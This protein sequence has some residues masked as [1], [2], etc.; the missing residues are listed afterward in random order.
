MKSERRIATG[1]PL[2]ALGLV[3][4][5]AIDAVVLGLTTGYFGG[6]YNS[7]RLAGWS[8]WLAFFAGGAV[9]DACLLAASFALAF[10]L[11]G[12]LRLSG[13]PRTVFA[14]GVA[15]LLPATAD[16]V[17]HQLHRVFGKVLG[18]DLLIELAGGRVSEAVLNAISEAP[19][20]L[21]GLGVAAF[22][23]VLSV[24]VARR[25]ER[26][27]APAA[28]APPSLARLAGVAAG[29]ALAGALLLHAAG[30]HWPV[31]AYGLDRKPAGMALRTIVRHATDWDRDGFGWLSR[32]PDAE[33]FDGTRHPHA[34]EIPGNAI[35]ENGIGGDR[36]PGRP[37]SLPAPAPLALPSA[38]ARPS[39][40]LIF[41]ESFRGDLIG[42]RL[43]SREVTPA[44][45]RLAEEGLSSELAF[46]HS[47]FTWISRAELFQGRVRPVAGAPGLIDDFRMRGYRVAYVS[48]QDDS[49]GGDELIGFDRADFFVDARS[50]PERKTSRTTLA[51]SLQVSW[52]LILEQVQSYLES[53][54]ADDRPVFL[55]V[56]LVDTHFPY[57]HDDLLPLLGV[58]P[59]RRADIR[60]WNAARVFDT[61][62]QSAANVDRAIDELLRIWRE[63]VGDSAIL[64]TADHGQAF[65]EDGM[66]GHGQSVADNQSRVPLVAVGMSGEW[67]EPLGMADLR[68]LILAGL[69]SGEGGAARLVRDPV[70]RLFQ[71]TGPLERP[72]EIALRSASG[73]TIVDLPAR[74]ARRL[75]PRGG[76]EA[77]LAVT[78]EDAR[79]VVWTWEALAAGEE[80]RAVPPQTR[81]APARA[82]GPAPP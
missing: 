21:L 9:L 70:R 54:R 14:A 26:R 8:D 77:P 3:F 42:R 38:S 31:V 27:L 45:N 33:P 1:L 19:A 34:I 32:P 63:H 61:Y 44:L 47:P 81:T 7:P 28:L 48:G 12:G 62:L 67:Q 74:R 60:P 52:R 43:G 29:A 35:D 36:P 6:G 82:S 53:T 2:L 50:N 71:F 80:D 73:L 37:G 64:V 68:R 24:G 25:I 79:E 18:L 22:A 65:Y 20:A 17:S 15:L 51:V 76:G 30:K 40:L 4:V 75:G 57:H 46:A 66:L 41:L 55:Y 59:I 78:S 23:V 11:A 10:L 69:F 5:A 39:F 72:K 58:D 16:V 49:H 56:N 13:L